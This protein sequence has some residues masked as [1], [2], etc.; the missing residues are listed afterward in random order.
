[1]HTLIIFVRISVFAFLLNSCAGTKNIQTPKPEII[2]KEQWGGKEHFAEMPEHVISQITIHHGG[3]EVSNEKEPLK[4]MRNLQKYSM[5][6]KKWMDIPYHY[7]IDLHGKIYECR[8]IQYPGDTNTEYDPTGH[9]LINVIGNYEIQKISEEQLQA[10]VELTAWLVE[11]YNVPVEAIA[12]H[13]DYSKMTVCPGK[14]LYKYLE[15]GTIKKRVA[16]ILS[17][18]QNK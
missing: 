9:A 4:Y 14:D 13:K 15:D 7:S 5:E 6:E 12:G 16:K 18:D 1:M 3:V 11:K 2:T 8:P 17:Q 10:I